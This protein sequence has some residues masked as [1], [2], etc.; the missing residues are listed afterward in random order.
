MWSLSQ[1]LT[2]KLNRKKFAGK[3]VRRLLLLI[4]LLIIAWQVSSCVTKLAENPTGTSSR[5]DPTTNLSIT[6][7]QEGH[8]GNIQK[9]IQIVYQ[10]KNKLLVLLEK[11]K[12]NGNISE[13]FMFMTKQDVPVRCESYTIQ[14]ELVRFSQE[15]KSSVET[16]VFL[17]ETGYF[18]SIFKVLIPRYYYQYEVNLIMTVEQLKQLP[19]QNCR[20]DIAFDDCMNFNVKQRVNN[21]LG[22]IFSNM[23]LVIK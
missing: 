9:P 19:N 11:G 10:K 1:M 18:R 16:K 8:Q 22:C 21:S 3:N 15:F 5:L 13:K 14:G 23:R 7:C 12:D 2:E 17:H 20:D 6:F 4:S